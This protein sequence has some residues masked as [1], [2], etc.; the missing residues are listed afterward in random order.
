MSKPATPSREE[1]A[2]V[3]LGQTTISRTTAIFAV[4][5]LLLTITVV[6]VIQIVHEVGAGGAPQVLD[7]FTSAPSE[8][9]FH[10]FERTLEDASVL[11]QNVLPPMQAML[12][13]VGCGNEQAYLAP[14]GWLFYRPGFDYVTGRG[15]LEPAVL[16]QRRLGGRSWEQPPQPDPLPAILQFRD[17]LR[18]RGIEL[19]LIRPAPSRQ[20]RC[21]CR[22]R[23]GHASS[24]PCRST[25][26]ASSTRRRCSPPRRRRS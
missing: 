5:L 8:R 22:T 21:R 11:G 20:V 10:Q 26:F 4:V 15:F 16:R 23:R 18:D 24:R 14:D 6:P 19:V 13:R 2:M 3:E 12:A 9:H 25:T 7:L 17:Q 1:V